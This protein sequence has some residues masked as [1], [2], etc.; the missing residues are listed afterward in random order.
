VLFT[1][2]LPKKATSL[3]TEWGQPWFGDIAGQLTALTDRLPEFSLL[4]E[5]IGFALAGYVG[6]L[7]LLALRHRQ[8]GLFG[9][10]FATFALAAMSLHVFAWFG[11][12]AYHVARFFLLI[13]GMVSDFFRWLS[14]PVVNFVVFV[15]S[16]EIGWLALAGI[17]G[18]LIWLTVRFGVAFL[19]GFG[20]AVGLIALFVGIIIGGGYLLRMVPDTFWVTVLTVVTLVVLWLFWLLLLATLGQLFLDQLRG[21][22]RAGSGQQGAIMG[23]LSVGS[24]LALLM[25]LG[26]A[27]SAYDFYPD[28][29]A[30][31]AVDTVLGANAPQFDAAIAL[32]VIGFSGLAVLTS[33]V[34]L[35]PAPIARTLGHSLIYTLIGGVIAT[36]MSASS[37]D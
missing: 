23:A 13:F 30:A 32:V 26:N 15:A 5:W 24:A 14:T 4:L 11:L 18:V 3:A 7:L 10:G 1:V 2:G 20:I 28:S 22:V 17:V 6:A 33:L 31:W 19:R 34:H 27:Y 36:V 12:I 21:A 9:W 37:R 29:V 25:L 35:R 8:F 16:G